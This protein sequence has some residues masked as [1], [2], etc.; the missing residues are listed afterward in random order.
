MLPVSFLNPAYLIGLSLAAVPVIVHLIGRQRAKTRRFAP[1]DLLLQCQQRRAARIRLRQLLLLFIRIMIVVLFVLAVSRPVLI[2]SVSGFVIGGEPTSYAVV[3]DNS[4]S[5]MYGE[6]E[7]AF[8]RARKTALSI[9]E[10]L[11]PSDNACLVVGAQR[12]GLTFD[13]ESL[14]SSLRKAALSFG[15]GDCHSLLAEAIRL[16]SGSSL[17]RKRIILL[18]DL[19]A[20]AWDESRLPELQRELKKAD[21]ALSIVDVSAGEPW[22]R[23]VTD[24]RAETEPRGERLLLRVSATVWNF[25]PRSVE[26]LPC[27]LYIGERRVASGFVDIPAFGSARKNLSCEVN[28]NEAVSGRFEIEK[29]PLPVDDV[30]YFCLAPAASIRALVV[31][32]EPSRNIIGAESFY[33]EK[34]LRPGLDTPSRILP[35]VITIDQ[36]KHADLSKYDV[37][38]LCN[39][40]VTSVDD[41]EAVRRF[42]MSG[43]GVF[44]SVGRNTNARAYND[45]LGFLLPRRLRDARENL[46]PPLS[47]RGADFDHPIMKVFSAADMASLKRAR[48][49][50]LFFVQPQA[51]EPATEILSVGN[52]LPLM[53]EKRA[54]HG[55]AILFLSTIDRE[56]N[57]FPIQTAFLPLMQETAKYLARSPDMEQS[58]GVFAGDDIRLTPLDPREPVRITAPNGTVY[59]FPPDGTVVFSRTN[60]AGIYRVENGRDFAV[61]LDAATES[62]L[63]KIGA[64]QLAALAGEHA[65]TVALQAARMPLWRLL[66]FLCLL[67]L[68]AE[69]VVRARLR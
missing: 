21:C 63:R 62:D 45:A 39:V 54:G 50:G 67:F 38:F 68:L 13:V 64:E 60:L 35:T 47:I 7:T 18:T 20:H 1:I 40:F 12:K 53:I 66:V 5:M 26:S 22:N 65:E 37:L 6:G 28:A 48:F 55:R 19:A 9:L 57:D 42:Y 27:S 51:G 4:Y 61:N 3:L 56:W 30:R 24:L 23:A 46:S 10:R 33:L 58:A 31:D 43:G 25:S 14:R 11:R 17:E 69:V 49:R 29:D 52:G 59:D 15:S 2:S 41:M 36:L 32:G 16:L 34:A 44:I 8:E